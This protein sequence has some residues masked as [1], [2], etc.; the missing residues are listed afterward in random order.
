MPTDTETDAIES[1][2]EPPADAAAPDVAAISGERLPYPPVNRRWR[3]PKAFRPA[4]R[5]LLR[6]QTRLIDRLAANPV[7]RRRSALSGAILL[8]LAMLAVLAVYGRVRIYVP[9]KPAESISVVFVDLPVSPPVVDLRDPEIAPEPEPVEE[10]ELKPEPEP[11]PT[12]KPEPKVQPAQEPE[13]EPEP[14]PEPEPVIDLTPEP[15]FA[16]PSDNENAPFIP[17]LAPAAPQPTLDEPR[18]GDIEVTGD[19]APSKVDQPLVSV[20]PEAKQKE[21]K[22]DSGDEEKEGDETGAGE[23][24]AGQKEDRELAPVAASKP[25]PVKKPTTG[26]D[27]FD[28]EPVFNGRRLAL[29]SVD[30]PKGDAAAI[31]G[32][33]GVVA[34]YCP[35]EFT[36]K[37]KIA[38]CAGRPEIRSGWRPGSSGE[39]FSKAAAALKN[40]NK[41][42]DFSDDAVT[43][44]PEIARQ[45]EQRR[46][47]EDLED[48]RKSQ[49]LGNAGIAPDPASGTRPD[50]TPP[51][52]DPSWTRRDDPL[53][54]QKDVE[55]LKRELEE[56]EK[57]KSPQ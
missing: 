7:R 28:E 48:F 54:D 32:T 35:E 13:P 50:L 27:M 36:D 34:I 44:G 12:P 23:V 17:E 21:S 51:V 38:E 43:F 11:T 9:N 47:V 40:R 30:L 37:E 31:P 24:A 6:W 33:S 25:A 52:A 20:E 56:A 45:I 2:P 22:K 46:R 26:D 41:H 8:N 39:D 14:T 3:T 10:P 15:A 19:Q 42:G 18:S 57:K 53:V 55:K 1:L 16:R 29:P 49:D 5:S 4:H